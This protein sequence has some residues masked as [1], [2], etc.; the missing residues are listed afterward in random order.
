M[1]KRMV[2]LLTALTLALT[3]S[4][5]TMAVSSEGASAAPE[6]PGSSRNAAEFCREFASELEERLGLNVGECVNIIAGQ[7]TGN[8]SR[9]IAGLCG[10]PLFRVLFAGF[11]GVEPFANKGECVST[12]QAFVRAQS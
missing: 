1:L 5:G 2:L 6:E 10:S 11:L 3:L 9:L 12:L 7:E 8:V 4:L